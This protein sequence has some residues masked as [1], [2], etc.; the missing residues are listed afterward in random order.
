[1]ENE[2][3]ENNTA[4]KKILVSGIWYIVSNTVIKAV[5]F[6]TMPIFT[7]LLTKSQFGDINNFGAWYSL[8]F[9][10]AS[11]SLSS[12]LARGRIDY[13]DNLYSF[14]KSLLFLSMSWTGMLFFITR[15]APAFF[16]NLFSISSKWLFF[17]FVSIAFTPATEMVLLLAYYELNYKIAVAINCFTAV[18]SVLV[19]L[20]L[21]K[22]LSDKYTARLLG[23]YLPMLLLGL[24]MTVFLCFKGGRIILGY[25]KYALKISLPFIPHLL[26][27]CV[28]NST[29]R[30][31]IAKMCGSEAVALYSMACTCAL[32]VQILWQSF[33]ASF[34]P[35]VMDMLNCNNYE[36]LRRVS[37]LYMILFAFLVV[38]IILIAPEMVYILGG[39][40]YI[41]AKFVV[42]PVILGYFF[43]FCYSMYVIIEQ[44]EKKTFGMAI[45]SVLAA[46]LN[47]GLNFLLIPLYG[48]KA[49]AYT[50]LI[51]FIFLFI[52]HFFIVKHLGL[53]NCYNT[54]NVFLIIVS[55][56][57][58]GICINILYLNNYFRLIAIGIYSL[59]FAMILI[60]SKN[61]I[62]QFFI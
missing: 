6:I 18:S 44:F 11:L 38:G 7:R 13:K 23:L 58:I 14:V 27:I 45:A 30:V 62:I 29:D 4:K 36:S 42:L 53:V 17:M 19:S 48:Y 52:V 50:T 15:L 22:V 31:M 2:K 25:W 28:L 26:A 10:F 56:L 55:M 9:I 51:G 8:M 35:F 3:V 61:R 32:V 21:M 54:R 39:K 16:E 5:G 47:V 20:L 34:T 49:A 57:L 46:T 43:Q 12:S 59:V 1:M 24:T 41:E 37:T 60:K 33:N 40:N